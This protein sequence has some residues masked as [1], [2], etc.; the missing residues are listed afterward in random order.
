MLAQMVFVFCEKI[1][2]AADVLPDQIFNYRRHDDL[3]FA[4]RGVDLKEIYVEKERM[5]DFAF[6]MELIA[7]H[8]DLE[9]REF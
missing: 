2:P 5:R 3:R 8:D 9:L 7:G 4:F 6:T 1:D